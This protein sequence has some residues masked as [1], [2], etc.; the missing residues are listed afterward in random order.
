VQRLVSLVLH[1]A[2]FSTCTAIDG[3]DGLEQLERCDPDVIVLDV[4]MPVMDGPTF[5]RAIRRNG[6]ETPV[7]ILSGQDHAATKRLPA[8]AH[9]VKPFA[10]DDLVSTV[11]RLIAA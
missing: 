11:Q 9:L 8:D 4:A 10:P 2:G 7:L 1:S 6:C 3:S 5:I